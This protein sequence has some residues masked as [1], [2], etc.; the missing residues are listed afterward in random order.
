[1]VTL[2]KGAACSTNQETVA[3]PAS[4]TAIAN[5]SSGV[6]ILF[7]FSSPPTIRSTA[8]KKSCLST[9]VLFLRAAVSAASL[10]TLAISAPEKPGVCFAKKSTSRS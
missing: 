4:C 3:C 6:M 5:F 2:T 7:F 10:H 9:C 1:M 8:S